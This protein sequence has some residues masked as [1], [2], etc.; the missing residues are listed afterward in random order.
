MLIAAL[1]AGVF[2]FGI[3]LIF[4]LRPTEAGPHRVLTWPMADMLVPVGVVTLIIMGPM[5][6]IYG[7]VGN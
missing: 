6:M 2:A 7:L 4:A 1:G 5:L 3:W